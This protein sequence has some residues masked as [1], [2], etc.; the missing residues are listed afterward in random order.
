MLI[1][2]WSYARLIRMSNFH[3]CKKKV[4]GPDVRGC[5]GFNAGGVITLPVGS[6]NGDVGRTAYQEVSIKLQYTSAN[7]F[8]LMHTG[9]NSSTVQCINYGEW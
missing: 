2:P 6:A 4:A 3:L 5:Y 9:H 7:I 8:T 1:R